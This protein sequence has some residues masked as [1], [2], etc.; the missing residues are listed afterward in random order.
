MKIMHK[1]LSILIAVCS[2]AASYTVSAEPVIERIS[3]TN[4]IHPGSRIPAGLVPTFDAGIS[5]KP[6]YEYSPGNARYIGEKYALKGNVANIQQEQNRG[7]H[8]YVFSPLYSTYTTPYYG[9]AYTRVQLPTSIDRG[10]DSQG[11]GLRNGFIS[12]GIFGSL[13]NYGIDMGIQYTEDGWRPYVYDT[14]KATEKNPQETGYYWFDDKFTIP[15]SK[16]A[17]EAVMVATPIDTTTVQFYVQF[18]DANGNEFY[19]SKDPFFKLVPI[20]ANNIATPGGI[21][22][23]FYYRFASLVNIDENNDNQNDGTKMLG[24]NFNGLA[25]YNTATR[26]YEDWGISTNLVEKAW[27][28][29]PECVSVS[30]TSNSETFNINHTGAVPAN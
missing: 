12:L 13:G 25:L 4:T 18:K 1:I 6:A 10:M 8:Y 9:E 3:K 17:T 28:V 11:N 15:D 5:I 29:T 16:G 20:K 30:W 23:C 26:K 22:A 19:S 27:K 14:F 24:G 7:S 2:L 21:P